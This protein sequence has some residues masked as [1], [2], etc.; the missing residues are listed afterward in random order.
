MARPRQLQRG[1]S[2]SWPQLE[3]CVNQRRV[4]G[5]RLARISQ[6]YDN[7]DLLVEEANWDVTPGRLSY[8]PRSR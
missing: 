8:N 3:R 5:T 7:L 1:S 4:L 6:R 2:V